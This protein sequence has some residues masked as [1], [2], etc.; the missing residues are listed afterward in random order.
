MLDAGALQLVPIASI[1]EAIDEAA[2]KIHSVLPILNPSIGEDL[3]L[4]Q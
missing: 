4:L 1:G 3:E 2:P